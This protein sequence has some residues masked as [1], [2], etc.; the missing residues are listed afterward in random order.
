MPGESRTVSAE[1]SGGQ[2]ALKVA[3]R[4]WN[5]PEQAVVVDAAQP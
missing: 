5:G 3:V 1:F 4:A 2:G